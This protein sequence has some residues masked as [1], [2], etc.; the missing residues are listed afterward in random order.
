[1]KKTFHLLCLV[2]VLCTVGIMAHLE[3][4]RSSAAK[5]LVQRA[6]LLEALAD[7]KEYHADKGMQRYWLRHVESWAEKHPSHPL[8]AFIRS[9]LDDLHYANPTDAAIHHQSGEQ[10]LRAIY[11]A[12]GGK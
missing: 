11:M 6:E 8:H 10:K 9:A 3:T 12:A 4:L 7:F 1:M 2:I 5:D